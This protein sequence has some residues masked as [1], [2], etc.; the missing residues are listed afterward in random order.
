MIQT[1]SVKLRRPARRINKLRTPPPTARTNEEIID[2]YLSKRKDAPKG[3][4]ILNQEVH[5]PS[6]QLPLKETILSI[7]SLAQVLSEKRFYAYQVVVAFRI[8]E[9]VLLHDGEVIT[10]LFSRQSGKTEVLASILIAL[11]LMLPVLA[12]KYPKDWRLNITDEQGNYRGFAKGIRIGIYA[13]KQ[14]QSEIMF[15][16][17]RGY[18]KQ[19]AAVKVMQELGIT[20]S[21]NNGNSVKIS[22]GS[23]VLCETA[24]EQSKIEGETHNVLVLE[25]AQDI[26][27]VKIRKSLHPMVSATMGTIVKI[28]TSK[29]QKCDFYE[30]IKTNER[31]EMLTGKRNHFFFPYT[32]C[33]KYNSQ[34]RAWINVE[35]NRL[36]EDSDEFLLSYACKWI[37]ERGMFV[38]D[39]ALFHQNV[40]ITENHPYYYFSNTHRNGVFDTHPHMSLVAGIDWGRSSDSTVITL[41]AVNWNEPFETGVGSDASGIYSYEYY[42]K[43]VIGWYEWIGDDYETQY[44]EIHNILKNLR[45]LRR[46]KL[47]SN[48]VGLAMMDRLRAD[49]YGTGIE[50]DGNPFN[51]NTKSD[52]YKLLAQEISGKRITF[53]AGKLVRPTLEYR[54][55]VGQ[56]LDLRKEYKNGLMY[57][58]HPDEK[59]ARD[60][61]PD[62]LM[63]A[64]QAAQSP[65][66]G[67]SPEVGSNFL[68]SR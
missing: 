45:G 43:H 29:S 61:Y 68:Y 51:R 38:T 37:F 22:H 65:V 52:G 54:K 64:C 24:S 1:K 49:F 11:A 32:V 2:D 35:K 19:D 59:H 3:P 20:M 6:D 40:A 48:S 42:L 25:E 5:N 27:D 58:S 7:I 63:L 44:H 50:I 57:V 30:A 12:K 18:L 36:G 9:S 10:A 21:E 39:T 26:G 4:R 33:Q 55:F 28:G 60:D 56:L 8:C 41:I 66:A 53:P 67:Y 47:D 16:R 13:P 17:I 31:S 15:E 46:V 62:S 23:R 34:Y 14:S